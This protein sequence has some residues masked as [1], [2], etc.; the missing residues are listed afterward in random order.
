M[1]KNDINNIALDQIPTTET[2]YFEFKSSNLKNNL[3]SLANK[4]G[5]AVSGFAN[6]GG[7]YFIIG[8]DEKTGNVDGGIPIKIGRLPTIDWIDKMIYQ[9]VEPTPLY[10]RKLIFDSKNRGTI[11]KDCAVLIVYIHESYTGPHMSD[12]KYYIR[13]GVHTD[14]ARNFIVEA[15]RAKR[16][17]SKPKLTHLFRLKP[18]NEQVLQLG[19]VALT[20][21][22]AINISIQIFPL[23]KRMEGREKDFPIAITLIDRNNPFY[24]DVS[25]FADSNE[26]FG[27]NITLQI[28]YY[29]ILSNKYYEERKIGVNN[30]TPPITIGSTPDKKIVQALES[31]EKAVSKIDTSRKSINKPIVTTSN[32]SLKQAFV[33]IQRLIPELLSEMRADL[34]DQP[35][36]REFILFSKHWIYNHDH[37]NDI[38]MYYYEDH[39]Y[40]RNKLRILENYG[41][42]YEITY[43]K[44]DRFVLLEPFVEYLNEY[45]S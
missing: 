30:A 32:E 42:V 41:L 22:S 45:N 35:F 36:I 43:N 33:N 26:K 31:I 3:D 28:E 29:D 37:N 16:Y 6:S 9:L 17:Q 4:L 5:K 18:S 8:I 1:I 10:E 2:E 14:P 13:A 25:L 15:I 40:L 39:T 34:V 38:F 19:I 27:D 12:G 20:D 21:A 7:G 44:V 11:D 24:F 23:P